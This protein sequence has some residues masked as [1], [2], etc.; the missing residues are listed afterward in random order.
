MSPNSQIYFDIPYP[1]I[2]LTACIVANADLNIKKKILCTL[3]LQT[4][5]L[6]VLNRPGAISRKEKKGFFE[7]TTHMKQTKK[8][9]IPY[10]SCLENIESNGKPMCVAFNRCGETA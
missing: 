5:T 8:P 7:N 2:D 6:D 9:A 3:N 10:A 1:C 4:A